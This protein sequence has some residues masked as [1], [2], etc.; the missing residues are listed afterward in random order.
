MVDALKKL[1]E[2]AGTK[3]LYI[4]HAFDP[5]T[6]RPSIRLLFAFVSY[7]AALI[8]IVLLHRD[9]ALLIPT[10]VS[11]GFFAF[12]IIMTLFREVDKL[13]VDAKER[14]FSISNDTTN[15]SSANKDVK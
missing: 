1:L 13:T 8:S 14:S 10:A 2:L 5:T 11:I 4:P 15:D 7:L 12:C 6:G 9:S 3:G